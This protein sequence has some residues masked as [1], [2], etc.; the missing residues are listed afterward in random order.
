[1]KKIMIWGTG[2]IADMVFGQCRTL[3][4]Y[5]LV[6]V[7]DNDKEKQGGIFCGILISPPDILLEQA[8][9]AIVVLTDQY[10]EI[11]RQIEASYPECRAVIENKNFFYKE[12]LVQRYR[13]NRDPEIVE[14]V[15]YIRENGLEIFN[16]P[17]AAKYK[18][19]RNEVRRDGES[20]LYFVL[21]KGKKMFF[22]RKFKSEREVND[23]YNFISMEQD[24][25]SPHR[26]LSDECCV[27]D[28]DVVL[29]VGVAEGNFALD[30]IDRAS[31]LYL[32][33]ADEGWIEA[34]RYTFRDYMDKVTL[35]KGYANSYDEG[36]NRTID[37][38]IKAPVQFIKMDIEGNEWDALR[39][40][41]GVVD[42]SPDLQ[43]AICSYHSDF[44]RELIEGFMD[45]HHIAHTHSQG[46]MWF[47]ET[48]RQTYVSISLNRGVIWGVK[49]E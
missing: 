40:A 33:E 6:G 29:D 17:F 39:G 25:K 9:D 42:A 48:I 7:I 47:P 21:H 28:G 35:V 20:G 46:Y 37:S 27:K 3:G 44:D 26:Y 14:A 18:D 12:S 30:V 49:N 43:M 24:E 10:E 23:Y 2:H 8:A 13:H 41:A 4:Q 45:R 31:H 15:D 1:M 36:H 32:L 38:L 5:E 11:K 34:L 22:S 19:R 16:Y